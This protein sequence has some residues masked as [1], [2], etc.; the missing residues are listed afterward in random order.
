MLRL[1]GLLVILTGS[2]AYSNL[3]A[4][5]GVNWSNFASRG[6]YQDYYLTTDFLHHVI[7]PLYNRLAAK[8]REQE[9]VD[10]LLTIGVLCCSIILIIIIIAALVWR[11]AGMAFGKRI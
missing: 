2:V 11:I 5:L 1:T 3:N 6:T 8:L 7:K 4:V 9:N 10:T